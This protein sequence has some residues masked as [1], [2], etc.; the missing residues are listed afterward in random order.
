MAGRFRFGVLPGWVSAL[1][2]AFNDNARNPQVIGTIH[3]GGYRLLLPVEWV[4][5]NQPAKSTQ[6]P[7]MSQGSA[8]WR[9]LGDTSNALKWWR[10]VTKNIRVVC[11]TSQW[12]RSSMASGPPL[13]SSTGLAFWTCLSPL[14]RRSRLRLIKRI[15]PEKCRRL[16]RQQ[17]KAQPNCASNP[18]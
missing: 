18:C 11:S 13:N 3:K 16:S 4:N 15:E 12:R 7:P 1:R 9:S 8:T 5:E 17:E 14:N 10:R 6:P 2:K